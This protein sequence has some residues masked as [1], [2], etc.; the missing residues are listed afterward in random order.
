MWVISVKSP[1][2]KAGF[3]C[4]KCPFNKPGDHDTKQVFQILNV[5]QIKIF[6]TTK[7]ESIAV[8]K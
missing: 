1:L 5:L 8:F 2:W 6:E 3:Y 4:W 7:S